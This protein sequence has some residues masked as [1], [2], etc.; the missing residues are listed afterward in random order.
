MAAS[1]QEVAAVD[2]AI[3]EVRAQYARAKVKVEANTSGWFQPPEAAS[4]KKAFADVGVLLERWASTYRTWA[5]NGRRDDGTAYDVQRFL[6]FGRKDVA[7]A[8][9]RIAG[10]AYD[11]SLFAAVKAAAVETATQVNPLN[12]PP[13]LKLAVGAGVAVLLVVAV[14]AVARR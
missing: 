7:D 11:R 12:W 6:D 1:A 9:E 8:V 10:E 4:I 14:V 5:V 3:R 13:G 2:K